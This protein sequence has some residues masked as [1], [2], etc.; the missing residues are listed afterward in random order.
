M[1]VSLKSVLWRE[2]A[3]NEKRRKIKRK[4]KTP[5]VSRFIENP[6][7]RF[8]VR[9]MT[10]IRKKARKGAKKPSRPDAKKSIATPKAEL[11]SIPRRKTGENQQ[12]SSYKRK[13][14]R[15]FMAVLKK[16]HG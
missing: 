15:P 6:V 11:L 10:H 13:R 5:R 14:G 8:F 9:K 1:N 3:I 7:R 12:S 2:W 4:K 16:T